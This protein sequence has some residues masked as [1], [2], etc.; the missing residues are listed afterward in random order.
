M[1]PI[2]FKHAMMMCFLSRRISR[3][4]FSEN[5]KAK[6]VAGTQ[7]II[8]LMTNRKKNF[9]TFIVSLTALLEDTKYNNCI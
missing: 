9:F 7:F 4:G 2:C 6:I 5:S 3:G 1:P 8:L